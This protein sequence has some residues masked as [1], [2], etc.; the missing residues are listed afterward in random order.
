MEMSKA[1]KT[2]TKKGEFFREEQR[3]AEIEE[4]NQKALYWHNY[5]VYSI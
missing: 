5:N 1:S 3:K 2:N 4:N